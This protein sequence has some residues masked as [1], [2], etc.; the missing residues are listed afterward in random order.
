M[1]GAVVPYAAASPA[2]APHGYVHDDVIE[3]IDVPELRVPPRRVRAR[4]S[5]RSRAPDG[6]VTPLDPHVL[7]L[8]PASVTP[9]R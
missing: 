3:I 1:S 2:H 5:S 6:T 9:K 4:G 7:R 8:P